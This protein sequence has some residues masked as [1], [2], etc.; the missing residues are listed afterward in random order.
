[1]SLVK[2]AIIG[3]LVLPAAELL[4][5]LLVAALIG[6]LWSAA[7]FV[8][9]SVAG[10]L[11]LRQ[12][13]RADID[14]LRNAFAQDGIR[15]MHLETPAWAPCSVESFWYFQV[16]SRTSWGRAVRPGAPPVDRRQA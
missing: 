11:L 15:A 13:G 8:A 3:L 4:A 9:T 14:R 12:S 5:F 6:W 2:W 1:M 16:L 10:V 7:L